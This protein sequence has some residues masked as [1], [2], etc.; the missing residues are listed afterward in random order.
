MA[1]TPAVVEHIVFLGSFSVSVVCAPSTCE[2][3]AAGSAL[4][5]AQKSGELSVVNVEKKRLRHIPENKF[6]RRSHN[7]ALISTR[8]SEMVFTAA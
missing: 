2:A 8:W 5:D 4:R 6:F 7:D 3:G 1:D